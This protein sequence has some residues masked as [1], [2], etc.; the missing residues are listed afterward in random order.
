VV[1]PALAVRLTDWLSIG[2]GLNFLA[3]LSG[4]VDTSAG[5]ARTLEPRID[6]KI[7][8]T[9]RLH[10]GLQ[11]DSG[12]FA[13]GLAFR[14]GFS[15]PFT[16]STNNAVAG[17]QIDIAIDAEGLFTPDE[18]WAGVAWTHQSVRLSLDAGWLRWSAWR[19]PYVTVSSVLPVAGPFDVTP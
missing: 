8:A 14:Q 9:V 2:V 12:P 19:G 13:F 5:A 15:V 11:L 3:G 16:T 18:V 4:K 6:E 1:L 17:E 10:A 7:F